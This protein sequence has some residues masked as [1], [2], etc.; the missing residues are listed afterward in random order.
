MAWFNPWNG[1]VPWSPS[2]KQKD[3]ISIF[4][5]LYNT[6]SLGSCGGRIIRGLLMSVV[7]GIIPVIPLCT[8][9]GDVLQIRFG[10]YTEENMGLTQ[11]QAN[12]IT[13]RNETE[14]GLLHSE[15]FIARALCA[16]I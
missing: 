13:Q 6:K 11:S 5:T 8:T 10:S 12:V 1:M 4:M 16:T 14:G 15:H 3:T 2:K 9:Y 7:K